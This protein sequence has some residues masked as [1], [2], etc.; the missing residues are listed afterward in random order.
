MRIHIAKITDLAGFFAGYGTDNGIVE[1]LVRGRFTSDD[2]EFYSYSEQLSDIFL[3]TQGVSSDLV[4]QFLVVIH[5]D[6]SADVY[7]N[8]IVVL[9]EI[10]GK[11][12]VKAGEPITLADIADIRKVRFPEL[13]IIR[14]WL[15]EKCFAM[16]RP[17]SPLSAHW[18]QRHRRSEAVHP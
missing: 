11:R 16:Q 12:T 15:R 13:E 17:Q 5:S 9:V 10:M 4:Y 2:D 18:C 7:V 3:H 6:S 14:P 8:D 1:L